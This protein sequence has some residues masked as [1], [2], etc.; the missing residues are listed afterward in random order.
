MPNWFVVIT[1]FAAFFLA[2]DLLAEWLCRR[3][4]RNLAASLARLSAISL[5]HSSTV[6]M[7]G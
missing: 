4:I 5:G 7:S 6:G 2:T 1:V 3:S